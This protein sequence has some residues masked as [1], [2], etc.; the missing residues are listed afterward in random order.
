MSNG[1]EWFSLCGN[2]LQR[3]RKSA[4]RRFDRPGA[5]SHCA[6]AAAAC[7]CAMRSRRRARAASRFAAILASCSGVRPVDTDMRRLTEPIVSPLFTVNLRA[8]FVPSAPATRRTA[9]SPARPK[10]LFTPKSH[11]AMGFKKEAPDK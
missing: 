1:T 5:S 9:A 8:S 11:P 10:T 4:S 3:R 7:C 6:G 2:S